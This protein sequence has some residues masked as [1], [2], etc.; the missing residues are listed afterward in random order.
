MNIQELENAANEALA[1]SGAACEELRT[2]E[3]HQREQLNPIHSE[4]KR[5]TALADKIVEATQP[6]IDARRKAYYATQRAKNKA[7]ADLT[8]AYAEDALSRAPEVLTRE[9]MVTTLNTEIASSRTFQKGYTLGD[10]IVKQLIWAQTMPGGMKNSHLTHLYGHTETS[11]RHGGQAG[12]TESQANRAWAYL[13][14]V[15]PT[16]LDGGL[17][18]PFSVAQDYLKN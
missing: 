11:Y 8:L 1:T 15:C 16:R 17:A 10:V 4:I 3:R 14:R 12:L 5:L 2:L 18:P 6:A 13:L 7:D 9:E